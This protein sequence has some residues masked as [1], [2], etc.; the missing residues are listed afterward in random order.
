MERFGAYARILFSASCAFLLLLLVAPAGR[1]DGVSFSSPTGDWGSTTHTFTIHG[2]SITATAF[3]GGNLF[4]K[5]SDPDETGMGL[6]DDPSGDHEI[7]AKMSGAQDYIQLDLLGLITAGF[8]NVKFQMGSTEGGDRWEVTA[9]STAGVSGSG[10]CSANASTLVGSDGTLN[11]APMNLS[12]TNHYLDISATKGNVLLDELQAFDPPSVPEPSSYA[13]L[14]VGML[15][16]AG[17]SFA[18]RLAEQK[19]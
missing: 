9:C 18:R 3:N 1:A 7:F 19:A 15:G 5:N 16:L 12:A 14:L 8:T 11:L 13:L 10:P 6:A 17:V 4:A 2:I